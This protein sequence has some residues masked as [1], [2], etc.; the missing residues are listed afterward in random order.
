[1]NPQIRIKN[2]AVVVKTYIPKVKAHSREGEWTWEW[3]VPND[4]PNGSNYKVRVE[5]RG[6]AIS[7]ENRIP[8]TIT[9]PIPGNLG[10]SKVRD[11]E[12]KR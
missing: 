11:K 6:G 4:I 12:I 7:G 9:G 8:F 2:G 1:M 3:L 5:D 10:N